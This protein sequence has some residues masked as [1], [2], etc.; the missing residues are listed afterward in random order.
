MTI[1]TY[2]IQ[3]V[4]DIDA[5]PAD[6]WQ[7]L[8]D[9]DSY[10]DWNPM[11]GKV[12]T[13]LETGA[14]VRMEVLRGESNPLKLSANITSLKDAEEVVWRGGNALVISGEHYFRIE[15]LDKQHCRLHHGENFKGLLVP[16]LRPTL[17]KASALYEAMNRALKQRVDHLT[18]ITWQGCTK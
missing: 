7:V 14:Q 15:Q 2:Q 13:R 1:F 9:F 3:T 17:R 6:I 5:C 10:P 18:I 12:Q 8:V 4:I 11:L 16:L